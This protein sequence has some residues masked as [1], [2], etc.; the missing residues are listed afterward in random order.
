MF[1]PID[2]RQVIRIEAVHRGFLYQHLYAAACLLLAGRNG[3]RSTTIEVDEDVELALENGGRAYLQI[4]T[5]SAPL[6]MS[7][8]SGP[9]ER[10]EAIRQ[11]HLE[12]RR[13][14]NPV[15]VVVANVEPGPE[16]RT[17]IITQGIPSGALIITPQF[18]GTIPGWLPPAW[19]NIVEAVAWCAEQARG[20]SMATLP[21]ETLIWK[22]AGRA[23]LAAA[24][25]APGHTFQTA[26]L[27]SLFEQMVVQLQRFPEPPE[28]YR[29]LDNEPELRL[30]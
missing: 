24:G 22:L 29:P 9:L 30:R 16:L 12:Q 26:D 25:Q 5:R 20:I 13:P 7:D 18:Q 10:F 3:V 11:E 23:Q 21:P 6:I 1:D 8:I 28:I 2:P 4:K 14:G 19:R 27:P 17:F 15:F